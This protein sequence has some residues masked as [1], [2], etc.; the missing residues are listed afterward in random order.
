MDEILGKRRVL[1][2][3]GHIPRDWFASRS[4]IRPSGPP[5]S[6]GACECE[7]CGTA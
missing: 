7:I 1:D 3:D 4:G 6:V 5:V 2:T